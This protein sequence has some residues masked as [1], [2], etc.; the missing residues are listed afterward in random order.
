MAHRCSSVASHR[1]ASLSHQLFC[2]LPVAEFPHFG[3]LFTLLHPGLLIVFS[4]PLRLRTPARRVSPSSLHGFAVCWSGRW[5]ERGGEHNNLA[6]ISLKGRLEG[7]RCQPKLEAV[8][9]K[10]TPAII[11]RILSLARPE[12]RCDAWHVPVSSAQKPSLSQQPS[13]TID[14]FA[15]WTKSEPG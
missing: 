6:P 7:K 11:T 1:I 13:R 4:N 3:T 9:D 12:S 8:G 14:V 2:H 15:Q 5:R 10:H